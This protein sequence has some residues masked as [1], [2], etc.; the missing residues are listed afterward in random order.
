MTESRQFKF[1]VVQNS[2]TIMDGI[3]KY[4][5]SPISGTL[6]NVFIFIV[7][8][9]YLNIKTIGKTNIYPTNFAENLER[10]PKKIKLHYDYI[11]FS[12]HSNFLGR[13]RTVRL[14]HCR[15]RNIRLCSSDEIKLHQKLHRPPPRRG[16]LSPRLIRRKQTKKTNLKS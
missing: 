4:D 2:G 13:L 7:N 14:Y 10:V 9:L 11:T 15:W 5:I 3:V 16:R 1:D 8:V 12:N 6:A